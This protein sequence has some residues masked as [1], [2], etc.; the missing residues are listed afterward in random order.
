MSCNIKN[1]CKI[2]FYRAGNSLHICLDSL[3]YGIWLRK[4]K[5]SRQIF[6]TRVLVHCHVYPLVDWPILTPLDFGPPSVLR[7]WAA[8][9]ACFVAAVAVGHT[10]SSCWISDSFACSLDLQLVRR[11]SLLCC[12]ANSQSYRVQWSRT[13]RWPE[14]SRRLPRTKKTSGTM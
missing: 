12:S 5:N 6:Q 10:R 14:N 8:I 4:M 2:P 1:W 9:A 7:C 11:V 13:R 3:T